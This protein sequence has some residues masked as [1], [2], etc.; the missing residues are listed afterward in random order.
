MNHC[1]EALPDGKEEGAKTMDVLSD[2]A[3]R[4]VVSVVASTW[5]IGFDEARAK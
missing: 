1:I 2:V 4:G 5:D 3:G